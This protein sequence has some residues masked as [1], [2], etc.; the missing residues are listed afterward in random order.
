[1][2]TTRYV[3]GRH[4]MKRGAVVPVASNLEKLRFT[5]PA[6]C[7]A[8]DPGQRRGRVA[9]AGQTVLE[10]AL[11]G[12]YG[13]ACS[14]AESQWRA[15]LMQV[16]TGRRLHPGRCADS[17]RAATSRTG[18]SRWCAAADDTAGQWRA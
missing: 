3:N 13:E 10:T 9:L 14:V 16:F 1:M 6:R 5:L 7:E 18:T 17:W 11:V 4:E 12:S 2:Q 8:V 15:R